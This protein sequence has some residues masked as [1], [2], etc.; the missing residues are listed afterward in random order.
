MA[1]PADLLDATRRLIGKANDDGSQDDLL[2]ELLQDSADEIALWCHRLFVPDGTDIAPVPRKFDADA[3]A[4]LDIDD[5]L[6]TPT[7]V[8]TVGVTALTVGTDYQALPTTL[9]ALWPHYAQLRRLDSTGQPIAWNADAL[10]AVRADSQDV[11]VLGVWAYA[12]TIPGPVARATQRLA[13]RLWR[14]STNQGAGGRGGSSTSGTG[15]T[16]PTPGLIAEDDVLAGL[17]RPYR[18]EG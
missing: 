4:I 3:S 12:A 7:P 1:Y 9:T 8:V 6:P 2:L 13:A 16:T 10:A 11:T 5:L 14:Q 15:Q 17:L 18:K